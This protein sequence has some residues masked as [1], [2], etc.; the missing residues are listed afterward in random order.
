MRK[1]ISSKTTILIGSDAKVQGKGGPRE[2]GQPWETDQ[3]WENRPALGYRHWET[4][5]V[6]LGGQ[7][8]S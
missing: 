8:G 1:T 4:D 7:V 6:V 5:W 2:T 3:P